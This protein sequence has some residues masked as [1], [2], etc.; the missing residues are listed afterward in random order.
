MQNIFNLELQETIV[1]I[2]QNR[3]KQRELTPEESNRF[4]NARSTIV[5]TEE[6]LKKAGIYIKS[7]P[8]GQ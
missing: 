1:D 4:Q 8:E 5:K 6:K 3:N 7:K 2:L